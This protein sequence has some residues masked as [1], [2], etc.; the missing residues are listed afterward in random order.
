MPRF[1]VIRSLLAL[2]VLLCALPAAAVLAPISLDGDFTDWSALAPLADDAGDDTGPVDW[3]RI[4]AANDENFLYLRFETGAE[5]QPDEQQ[6]MRLYLDTDMNA[7]TGTSY[8]GIGADLVWEFGWRQGDFRGTYVEHADVGLLMAPTVSSTEF[9]IALSR[10][11]LPNGSTPLFPGNQV[12][13][14]L[15]DMD[16]GDVAP[17]TGAAVYTFAAGSEP[18]PSLTLAR[19][20]P[21]H[22]R[23]ATWNIQNDGLFDGGSA[24]AAQNRILDAID[25]DVLMINEAW[26]HSASQVATQIGVLLPGTAW[27]AVKL[28]GGNVIVSR[29]PIQQSWEIDPGYRLT[30]ALLDLGAEQEKDLLV[31]ACHWRCCTA[32][33]DRQNEADAVIGFL[34]D[35][36][37]AGG[38]ITLPE[39]TPVVLAGDLNLVGW[40]QQL[41]TLLTGDIQDEA[42]YGPDA[43]PDWDGSDFSVPPS[44]HPD[45]R[46]NYTWRNDF[47]DF[48]PGLLDW[49]CYTGSAL[50]L[51]NHMVLE[52]RTMTSANLA[53][54]GLQRYDVTDAGDHAPRYAD[55]T[56]AGPVSDVPQLAAAAADLLPASPNPFNPSTRLRFRLERP[57]AVE[58]QVFDA[59]GRQVRRFPPQTYAPGEHAA[60]WDGRDDAGR[61][62]GSGVFLVRMTARTDAGETTSTGSVTLVE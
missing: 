10:S 60:V 18:V 37:A 31:I 33:A 14:L 23:I 46:A 39:G 29:F 5:V 30:A 53:L 35:A 9:E 12:R 58:L 21:S 16:S 54:H 45:L 59:R 8:G 17:S 7:G 36:R 25:P 56:L 48:Y 11:A 15:R 6:N 41:L 52:T 3:G 40:R 19:W 62:L 28:D 13:F 32:D 1:P 51:H 27:N 22:L 26:N 42:T 50:E 43:A 57:A 47:S 4:W 24:E 38:V 49:I 2:G 55:F 20:D 44:R 34:R 61:A